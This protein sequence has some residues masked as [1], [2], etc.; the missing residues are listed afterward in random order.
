MSF[1]H[2]GYCHLSWLYRPAAPLDARLLLCGT[3]TATQHH[4]V[5]VVVEKSEGEMR[6]E[7]ARGTAD[8][9]CFFLPTGNRQTPTDDSINF[10]VGCS[11]VFHAPLQTHSHQH[12]H[13]HTNNKS[14]ICPHSNAPI[15]AYPQSPANSSTS[16]AFLRMHWN[17]IWRHTV[18][19]YCLD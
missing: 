1:S 12:T 11:A 18:H 15:T 7:G 19:C 2:S 14:H 9:H 3:R 5:V 10:H 17:I 4:S 13:T 8:R 16:G 6:R